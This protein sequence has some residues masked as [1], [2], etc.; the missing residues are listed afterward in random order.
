MVN[1]APLWVAERE[2]ASVMCVATRLVIV[3]RIVADV[4]IF[5]VL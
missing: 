5:T 1:L 2:M 4:I 3:G